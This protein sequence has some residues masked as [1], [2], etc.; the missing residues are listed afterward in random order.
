VNFAFRRAAFLLGPACLLLTGCASAL[1]QRQAQGYATASLNRYCA[2]VTPCGPRRIGGAQRL[3]EGWL[4]D[5]D[6]TAARY[7]VMVH[8]NRAT[9]V[10][11]WRKNVAAAPG[12]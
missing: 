10:S 11:V 12:G 2:S 7:A 5:F 6:S 4:V 3:K 9:E 1:T 8:D